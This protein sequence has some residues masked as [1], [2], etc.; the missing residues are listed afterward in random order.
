[1]F[2][3]L[4]KYLRALFGKTMDQ[5]E[6]P[7]VLLA[8]AQAEMREAQAKNRERAVAAITA[9]NSLQ[10]EVDRTQKMVD[11][12]QAKAE[13]ALKN[14]DRET[15][16]LLLSEKQQYAS[17]LEAMAASL[18]SANSTIEAVKGAIKHEEERIRQKTAQAMAL[19]TQWKSSQ[20][21]I[22][23]N[24]AMEGIDTNG[25]DAAFERAANRI[26]SA[27][28]ESSARH[29]LAAGNLNSRLAA[30]DNLQSDAAADEELA[31]MEQSM[32]LAPTPVAAPKIPV[33]DVSVEEQ[34]Q[35]LEARVGA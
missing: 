26:Q 25:H 29:E 4:M 2:S 14:G 9:R 35:R 32:G 20:I 30:L 7:D 23:I 13:M 34:L 31:K 33:Q 27:A 10:V 1:M 21:E 17:T 15:A 5:V 18:T 11:G 3:R 24:K 6:D 16:R 8:Q 22:S 28:S 12:L 19:K